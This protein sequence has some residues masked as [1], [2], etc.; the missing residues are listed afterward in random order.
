MLLENWKVCYLRDLIYNLNRFLPI[1]KTVICKMLKLIDTIF[2]QM[3]TFLWWILASL[4][5]DV[6]VC[7]CFVEWLRLENG[8]WCWV[9]T[10]YSLPMFNL[11][12]ASRYGWNLVMCDLCVINILSLVNVSIASQSS[13]SV[14]F[15]ERFLYPL[16]V[17]VS[18]L[19]AVI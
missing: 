2:I 14:K 13:L 16:N 6:C 4:K 3:K 5:L 8:K 10:Y 17:I 7:V 18:L 15:Y 12:C 1:S 11:H 9:R 19:F